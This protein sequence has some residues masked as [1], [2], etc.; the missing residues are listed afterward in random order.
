MISTLR[1]LPNALAYFLDRRQR[2]VFGVI[3]YSRNCRL[4]SSQ[5]P[6]HVILSHPGFLA[7]LSEQN[8]DFEIGIANLE[9][10]SEFRVQ[11]L[12]FRN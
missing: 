8:P 7:C 12:T 9:A 11:A 10:F 3:L 4:L 2:Y 5:S 6:R 1:F